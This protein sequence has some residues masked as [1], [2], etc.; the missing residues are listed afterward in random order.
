[1]RTAKVFYASWEYKD[2]VM[3]GS[4]G[5]FGMETFESNARSLADILGV[6]ATND[7]PTQTK[8]ADAKP[9]ESKPAD[10]K[11]GNKTDGKAGDKADGKSA[12]SV[13]AA[14]WLA[15]LLAISFAL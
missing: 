13:V 8:S 15:G 9:T 7:K 10:N 6:K 4:L 14:S 11:S 2:A 5:C 12:A 1:M 3:G